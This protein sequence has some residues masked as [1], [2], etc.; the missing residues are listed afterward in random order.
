MDH[1]IITVCL[2]NSRR[3]HRALVEMAG[4]RE[5]GEDR[6]MAVIAALKLLE[7]DY[8]GM[9][10]SEIFDQLGEKTSQELQ[11]LARLIHPVLC[12]LKLEKWLGVSGQ[13]HYLAQSAAPR[14]GEVRRMLM[15]GEGHEYQHLMRSGGQATLNR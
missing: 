3:I 13:C 8:E 6:Q 10:T 5:I 14:G 7:P 11:Q 1:K 15:D 12:S 9:S 4:S 2:M